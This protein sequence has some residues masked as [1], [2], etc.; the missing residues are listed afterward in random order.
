MSGAERKGFWVAVPADPADR[1]GTRRLV[2][3][4]GIVALADAVLLGFLLWA[5]FGDRDGLVS[6]L[7]PIH[8]AGF[9]VLLVMCARGASEERWGWWFPAIVILTFGPLGSLIGD[10][11][12]RRALTA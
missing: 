11:I 3:W 9:V 7:G 6:V 12:V 2:N 10:L 1:A 5:S 8:G 4:I